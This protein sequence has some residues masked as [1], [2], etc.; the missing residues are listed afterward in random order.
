M[1][2]NVK[3]ENV[4]NFLL[5]THRQSYKEQTLV[6]YVVFIANEDEYE[7]SQQRRLL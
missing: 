3:F 4:V 5:F 1:K 7:N 2:K 6:A